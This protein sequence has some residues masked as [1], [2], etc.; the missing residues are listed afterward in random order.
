M[1]IIISILTVL[2]IAVL[3]FVYVKISSPNVEMKLP[4]FKE[5]REVEKIEL[6]KPVVYNF[7]ARVMFM[8]I[9]FRNYKKVVLYKVIIK[10]NDRFSAFNVKALLENNNL[11]YTMF[12]NGKEIIIYILFRNLNEAKRIINLFKEYNFNIKLTKQIQRI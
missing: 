11:P 4:S 1:K 3:T 9:D 7:P 8:K 5:K 2:I 12:E 10:I 6:K